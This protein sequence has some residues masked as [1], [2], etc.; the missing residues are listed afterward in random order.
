MS[1]VPKITV[2]AGT[3]RPHSRSGALADWLVEGYR[4]RGDVS[5]VRLDL[6]DLPL[7][8]ASPE[9]FA[10]KPAGFEIFARQILES[11]GLHIVVP[12][13]NGGFPGILKLF[14]DHLPFPASFDRR[15]VALV[16]V[17]SGQ[18]GALRP[19]EQ[20]QGVLGY[21][22]AHLYP[23]RV[24]IAGVDRALDAAGAPLDAALG[25]RLEAQ[26]VGFVD[27]VRKVRLGG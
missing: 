2:F 17:S 26:S 10:K 1:S 13:Y 27:F 25:A 3:N 20:L 4:A 18:F 24:F 21:R 9:A 16:G 11:D 22:N 14:I 12:E 8:L 23:P 15:P 5:V 6:G 19:I 7:D